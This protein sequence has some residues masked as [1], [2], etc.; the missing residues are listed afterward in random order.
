MHEELACMMPSG[1]R[2]LLV[3]HAAGGEATAPTVVDAM[4]L[5]GVRATFSCGEAASEELSVV[6]VPRERARAAPPVAVAPAAAARTNT[7]DHSSS[8]SSQSEE[9]EEGRAAS[10]SDDSEDDPEDVS[11]PNARLSPV[12][13][14]PQALPLT[15]CVNGVQ[16]RALRPQLPDA[17]SAAA[18]WAR[19]AGQDA[20][21][22]H[23]RRVLRG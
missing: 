11:V 22:Q 4:R 20:G 10:T 6:E 19:Y 3:F 18:M 8:A 1:A 5:A 12:A 9:E 17:A 15:A 14:I 13:P 23:G 16:W 2:H 21:Q 7:A